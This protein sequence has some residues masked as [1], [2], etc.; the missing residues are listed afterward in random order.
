MVLESKYDIGDEVWII[1][2]NVVFRTNVTGIFILVMKG[3]EK[4]I[5]NISYSVSYKDIKYF[6]DEVFA[7]KE[8]LLK[9]L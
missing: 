7:S 4:D 9:T 5:I 3:Y 8:E 6:E 1:S 2:N